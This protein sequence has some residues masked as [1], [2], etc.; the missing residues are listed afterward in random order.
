MAAVIIVAL[1]AWPL[2]APRVVPAF[3]RRVRA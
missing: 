3:I 1:I 2:V